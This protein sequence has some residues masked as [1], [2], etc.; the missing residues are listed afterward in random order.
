M[1]RWTA[2]ERRQRAKMVVVETPSQ[3][4]PSMGKSMQKLNSVTRVGLNLHAVDANGEIVAAARVKAWICWKL[5]AG[6][7]W[8]AA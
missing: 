1:M 3:G 6:L 2:P 4:K 5:G 8:P 7:T